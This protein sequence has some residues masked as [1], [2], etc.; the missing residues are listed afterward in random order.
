[1]MRRRRCVF[2]RL[3]GRTESRERTHII[4]KDSLD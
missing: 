4:K 1:M 3:F 2:I